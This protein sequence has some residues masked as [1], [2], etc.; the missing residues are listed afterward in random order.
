MADK[1][2]ANT[3]QAAEQNDGNKPI[4]FRKTGLKCGDI[5]TIYIHRP[6]VI[7]D[8]HMH[9]QSGNC[10]T[11]P[12]IWDASPFPLNKLNKSTGVSRGSVE[13]PGLV[14]SYI[15]DGLFEWLAIPII[16]PVRAVKQ[17]VKDDPQNPREGMIHTSPIRQLLTQQKATTL[18]IGDAFMVERD[19]VLENFFMAQPE[20]KDLSHQVLA[21]VVM[22]MDMEYAHLDGYYGLKIYNAI[23]AD[24][25]SRKDPIGYWY[26]RHGIWTKRGSHYESVSGPATLFPDHGMTQVEY[27]NY[28]KIAKEQKG[29][30]GAYPTPGGQMELRRVKAAPVKTPKNETKRYEHWL[31]QLQYTEQAML[32]HPLKILPMF[33]FDPRRWQFRPNKLEVFDKVKAGG[34]YLGFKMYTAQGYR[35]WDINRL[36]ILADFYAECSRLRI[37]ILNHCTPKGAAT[38]EQ[39]LYYDF[40]HPNDREEELLQ[41]KEVR[42]KIT[43]KYPQ[44]GL[45]KNQCFPP[46]HDQEIK[47]TYFQE[48]FV[49]PDTWN[50]V[51]KS[52]VQGRPLRDLHLCLAHFG[53]PTD[54]GREWSKQIIEMMKTYQNFYADISSSFASGTFRDHFRKIMVDKET[55]EIVRDRV[56]FGTDWYMTLLYTAPFHGMNYWDYCTETKTFLDKIDPG[57]WPRFTMHNPYRFYRLDEQVPRIAESIIVRRQTEE[58]RKISPKPELEKIKLIRKEAAW[59]RQAND[60][61]GI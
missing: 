59:I 6:S 61:F 37:P 54:Q 58:M 43:A 27:D 15:L 52:T 16:H 7:I 55:F 35:P 57:L 22:T 47:R 34:L 48:H 3:N 18:E 46:D 49:S 14:G 2:N 25:D 45:Q 24:E 60:G 11:L 8:S 13:I 10:A 5:N 31:K 33:H 30:I 53:G 39:E 17:A 56:L 41:K 44:L 38:V 12:F 29:I 23:Y 19:N 20:Y 21:A 1:K 28:K 40:S 36:P 51:L 9:I 42:Q 26:P 4:V 32:T 50:K